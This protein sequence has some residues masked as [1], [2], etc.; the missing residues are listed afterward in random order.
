MPSIATRLKISMY[1]ECSL[2]VSSCPPPLP[3]AGRSCLWSKGFQHSV[4]GR[5][6]REIFKPE[7][8][9]PLSGKGNRHPAEWIIEIPNGNAH[10]SVD[11][12][13]R[14]HGLNTTS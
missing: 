2:K 10:A 4:I 9:L 14:S 11:L 6:L 8:R 3:P 12:D 5:M 13:A 7:Q 1:Y